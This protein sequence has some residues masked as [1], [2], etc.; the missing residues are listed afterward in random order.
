MVKR[1]VWGNCRSDTRYPNR[2]EGVSFYPFPKP[3]TNFQKCQ[4]WIRLCGRPQHRLNI[5]TISKNTYVCSKHFVNGGP[6]EEFP[7]PLDALD[8]KNTPR[9]PPKKKQRCELTETINASTEVIPP[10]NT[11]L[12]READLI[13]YGSVD[14]M[15]GT[16]GMALRQIKSTSVED[17]LRMTAYIQ[18]EE[19]KHLKKQLSELQYISVT[20]ELI[21]NS[22]IP[23]YFEF[24]T[25]FTFD[26]FNRLCAF[27]R[28]PTDCITPQTHIPLTYRKET[29]H[30][31]KMPFRN[32]FLL[33][34]MKL[35]NNYDMKD[36]AFKFQI[37]VKSTNLIF[38]AWINYLYLRLGQIPVWPHRD[39]ITAR[40]PD[41]FKKDF[42]T[43]FALLDCTELK[44]ERPTSLLLPSQAVSDGKSSNTLKGLVAC[45]PRGSILFVS[46]LY[47]GSISDKDIFQQC[48]ITSLL[49]SLI[50]VGYLHPG[51][52]LMADKSFQNE[53]DVEEIGLCLSIPPFTKGSEQKTKKMAKHKA[54]VKRAVAKIKKFKIVSD[55]I[56]TS[57]LGKIN[58]IWFV[59]SMLTNF[60]P[61]ILGQ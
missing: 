21:N 42:P 61:H 41:N 37:D 57:T 13:P 4:L 39:I 23:N 11:T 9:S 19:I 49:Y 6:T 25:G 56:H 22:N 46:M 33:V 15:A 36:L 50:Q 16:G 52:A 58:Q 43:T 29:W 8:E 2:V 10:D 34:L 18:S 45:D 3:K 27:L 26:M 59:V 1:C 35:R 60:Q 31:K 12:A 38:N 53:K 32:Q 7:D 54:N 51:D 20:P 47:A 55:K 40:M 30:T 14:I 48:N 44:L 17:S 28:V 5:D 24:C